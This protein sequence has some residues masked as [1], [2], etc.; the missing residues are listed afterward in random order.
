MTQSKVLTFD[1]QHADAAGED[2]INKYLRFSSCRR[3]MLSGYAGIM[4]CMSASDDTFNDRSRCLFLITAAFYTT[5]FN[6]AL[7]HSA[8]LHLLG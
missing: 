5:S 8:L 2:S 1:L 4:R 6:A 3:I 7:T